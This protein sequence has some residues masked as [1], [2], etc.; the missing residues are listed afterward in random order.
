MILFFFI[1]IIKY[2]AL[3]INFST[4]MIF[5]IWRGN[6][7]LIYVS[8]SLYAQFSLYDDIC[9]INPFTF[10]NMAASMEVILHGTGFANL[11]RAFHREKKIKR[12]SE[13]AVYVW[14]LMSGSCC[15]V[16]L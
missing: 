2:I 3:C 8:T 1:C 6:N 10:H 15:Y 11:V 16:D 12:Y 4:G 13:Q 5:F 9:K 7:T 14:I